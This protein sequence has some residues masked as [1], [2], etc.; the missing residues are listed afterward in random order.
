MNPGSIVVYRQD[1]LS[2]VQKLSKVCTCCLKSHCTVSA[3]PPSAVDQSIRGMNPLSTFTPSRRDAAAERRPTVGRP[4]K[5]G[6]ARTH[7]RPSR[8]DA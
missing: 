5:A 2:E 7:T 3:P 4:F 6:L 8:S 1:D